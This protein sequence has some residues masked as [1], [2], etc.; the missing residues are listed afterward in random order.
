[1]ESDR[2]R[3]AIVIPLS[4]RPY[5]TADKEISYRHLDHHLGRYDK[6]LIAPE[7]LAIGFSDWPAKRFDARYFGSPDAH[8]RLMLSSQFYRMFEEYE[9]ILLYHL[10]ALV[11]SDELIEWCDEEY[12]YIGAP[13]LTCEDTPFVKEPRVGCGR[14][15]LRKIESFLQVLN[16]PVYLTD[17]DDYWKRFRE[18]NPKPLVYHQLP[19]KVPQTAASL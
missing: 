7:N 16:S 9:Y 17:P 11:F 6:Y 14:F 19:A 10:D 15:S 5:L 1:M 8:K 2:D 13:W 18:L 3:V 4:N 12:D